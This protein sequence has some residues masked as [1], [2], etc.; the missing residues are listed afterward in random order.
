MR[1]RFA[2]LPSWAAVALAAVVATSG[3]V[4]SRDANA[5]VTPNALDGEA[6]AAR[7]QVNA[8]L[9]IMESVARRARVILQTARSTGSTKGVECANEGLSRVDTALRLGKDHAGRLLDDW[10]HG[11]AADA[12][13]ELLRLSVA[14]DSARRAGA[15]NE[16]CIDA[17]RPTEGTTVRLILEP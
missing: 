16:T 4:G 5:D 11:N 13:K 1:V 8:S 14:T 6:R 3:L 9:W 17:P 15:D 7:A 2:K 10:A 12:R